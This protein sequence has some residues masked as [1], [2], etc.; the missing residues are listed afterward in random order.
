MIIGGI[1]MWKCLFLLIIND[2]IVNY[3]YSIKDQ[4]WLE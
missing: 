4:T 1:V 2:N 3:I